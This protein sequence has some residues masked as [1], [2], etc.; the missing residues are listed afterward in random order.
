MPVPSPSTS[1]Q[2]ELT[3]GRGVRSMDV[4]RWLIMVGSVSW[5]LTMPGS[6]SRQWMTP[7]SA[8]HHVRQHLIVHQT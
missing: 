6:V 1:K 3:D 4:P 2:R 8:A 5:L 7:L